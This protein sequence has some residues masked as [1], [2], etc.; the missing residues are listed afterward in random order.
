[1]NQRILCAIDF[2]ETSVSALRHA[3][4]LVGKME[5]ELVV[6]HAFKRPA[7]WDGKRQTE[8]SDDD[9]R[10]QIDECLMQTRKIARPVLLP[11]DLGEI[12]LAAK[13]FE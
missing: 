4:E 10:A 3:E 12:M 8:P 6:A 13:H 2:P 5:G 7:A 1:M 9:V 11:T